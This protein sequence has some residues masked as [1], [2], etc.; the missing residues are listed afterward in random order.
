MLASSH[1]LPGIY[2]AECVS[3][4]DEYTTA[5]DGGLRTILVCRATLGNVLYTDEKRPDVSELERRCGYC[6]E[7]GTAECDSVL[8]DRE[9]CSKT[10]R[11]FVAFDDDLVY[12]EFIVRYRRNVP[13]YRRVCRFVALRGVVC[14]VVARNLDQFSGVLHSSVACPL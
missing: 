1:A 14:L 7:T 2:L 4:S 11:E 13:R 6:Q 3:K 5:E 9:V 10:Y 12:P 8:G